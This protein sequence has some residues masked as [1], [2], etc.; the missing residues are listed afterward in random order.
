MGVV[1]NINKLCPFLKI[2]TNATHK[3]IKAWLVTYHFQHNAHKAQDHPAKAEP[4]NSSIKNPNSRNFQARN[5]SGE[6]E[7]RE[8]KEMSP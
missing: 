5:I 7:G 2:E 6:R 4:T 3:Q 8:S 1:I